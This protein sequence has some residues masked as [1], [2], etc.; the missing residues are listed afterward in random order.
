MIYAFKVDEFRNPHRKA[1]LL[2]HCLSALQA[3]A[4]KWSFSTRSLERRH[5]TWWRYLYLI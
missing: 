1:Q 3:L 4:V 2:L 5:W